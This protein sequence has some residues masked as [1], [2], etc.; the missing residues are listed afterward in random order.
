MIK[1]ED[2]MNAIVLAILVMV[3]LCLARVSVVFSLVVAALMGGLWAGMSVDQVISAFN[4]GLGAVPPWPWPTPPWEPLRWRC[5]APALP[6][7][8]RTRHWPGWGRGVIPLRGKTV[9]LA[10]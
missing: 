3:G 8:C 1:G 9:R 5:R 4:E 7:W 2:P 10:A 6:P